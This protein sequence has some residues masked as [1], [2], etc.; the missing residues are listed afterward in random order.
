MTLIFTNKKFIFQGCNNLDDLKNDVA[1]LK[2]NS[3]SN[4]VHSCSC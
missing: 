3:E 4:A 2:T 1:Q